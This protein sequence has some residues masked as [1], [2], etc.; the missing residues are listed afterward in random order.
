MYLLKIELKIDVIEELRSHSISLVEILHIQHNWIDLLSAYLTLAWH[1][2]NSVLA[3]MN[4][5]S[6]L[7]DSCF[8]L[9]QLNTIEESTKLF[10]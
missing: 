5:M 10:I 6:N 8:N 1:V 4:Y 2:R 9:T 7:R 3:M